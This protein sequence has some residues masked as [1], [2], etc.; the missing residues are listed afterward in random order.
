VPKT[1]TRLSFGHPFPRQHL[2]G[3]PELPRWRPGSNVRMLRTLDEP[4]G[5]RVLPTRHLHAAVR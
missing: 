5:D 4:Q 1:L 2:R 3:P